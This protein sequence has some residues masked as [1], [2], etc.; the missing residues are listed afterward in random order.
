MAPDAMTGA[1][2]D[3]GSI[4][5]QPGTP[6][7]PPNLP[8]GC[9]AGGLP[10][11]A[12]DA[13][14]L[15]LL[16]GDDLDAL[17]WF[18]LSGD[19][20]PDPPFTFPAVVGG[21]AYIYSLTPASPSVAAGPYSA[22]DLLTHSPFA[23]GL[24]P[25]VVRN[26]VSLGLAAGD[27]VDAL[28]CH[29]LD[30]DLDGLP[31]VFDTDDTDRDGYPDEAE[32]GTP[33]CGANTL[34]NDGFDDALVNDGCPAVGPAEADCADTTMVGLPLD[35]DGDGANNDGC[36][37]LF[38][39]EA[40]F[41]IGTERDEPCD[42]GVGPDPSTAWPS[43]FVSAGVPDSTDVLTITDLT[44]FI[45]PIRHLD[46][47]PSEVGF[48][49]RWDIAPGQTFGGP[50]ADWIQVTDLTALFAGTTGFPPNFGGLRPFNTTTAICSGP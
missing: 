22:A 30:G 38:L 10:C 39:S 31:D 23:F 44:S 41:D 16:A 9:P 36:P 46:T 21:D 50:T 15:G 5:A 17:C 25:K 47:D 35:D 49:A 8:A 19:T 6:P 43:D 48:S 18:D 1:A 7:N 13:L 24:A 4:L 29:Q 34:N 33:L 40:A 32:A 20:I 27:D 12:V 45:A 37:A 14:L 26:H 11:S 28:V 42:P 3:G 2:P